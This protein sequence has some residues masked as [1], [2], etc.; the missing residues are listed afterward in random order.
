MGVITPMATGPQ[1]TREIFA[2][3]VLF[4]HIKLIRDLINRLFLIIRKPFFDH[5]L[6]I[7]HGAE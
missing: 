7:M 2:G 5:N 1:Q 6:K 3:D 4:R